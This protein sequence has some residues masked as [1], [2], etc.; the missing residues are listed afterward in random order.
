MY[1]AAGMTCMYRDN[2]VDMTTAGGKRKEKK[3]KEKKRKEKKR[4]GVTRS[5]VIYQAAQ[6]LLLMPETAAG[7]QTHA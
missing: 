6:R 5:L 4:K 3:R 2:H 1:D 7:H